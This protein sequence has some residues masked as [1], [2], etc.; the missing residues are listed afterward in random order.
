MD[1]LIKNKININ[2]EN[3][4]LKNKLIINFFRIKKF[5]KKKIK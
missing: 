3:Y 2:K 5:I 1:L 4:H